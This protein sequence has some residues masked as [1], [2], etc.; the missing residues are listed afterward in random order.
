MKAK[1]IMATILTAVI[2]ATTASFTTTALNVGDVIGE[3]LYTDIVASINGQNIA[4]YNYK[5]HIW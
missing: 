4:S 3:T 1:R 5:G 2:T